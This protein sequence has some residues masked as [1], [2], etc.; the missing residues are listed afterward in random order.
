MANTIQHKRSSTTGAVPS[1]VSLSAGELAVNTADGKVFTKKDNGTVVEIG[2]GG[3]G[4]ATP[5]TPW[6]KPLTGFYTNGVLVNNASGTASISANTLRMYPVNFP[7][8]FSINQ[9]AWTVS[10]NS[11]G[12]LVRAGIYGSDS[13]GRPSTSALVETAEVSSGTFGAKTQT[14]SYSINANTQ[15]WLAIWAGGAAS[16][17]TTVSSGSLPILHIVPNSYNRYISISYTATYSSSG[18]FPTLSTSLWASFGNWSTAAPPS[19]FL[20]GT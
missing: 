7:Y 8:S 18:S 20:R 19:V 14:V 13:S 3:G 12:G 9:M 15:Y 4:S 5:T 17:M 6:F 10:A 11:P 16:N 1:S 2:A